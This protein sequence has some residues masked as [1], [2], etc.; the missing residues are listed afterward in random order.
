MQRKNITFS[1]SKINARTMVT[2]VTVVV[3]NKVGQSTFSTVT[4]IFR[5]LP[6]GVKVDTKG[7]AEV[8]TQDT[9]LMLKRGKFDESFDIYD[10]AK[11]L[12][13][14]DLYQ[15]FEKLEQFEWS[16]AK[17]NFVLSPNTLR[18]ESIGIDLPTI[19]SGLT[20]SPEIMWRCQFVAFIRDDKPVFTPTPV[21]KRAIMVRRST[22]KNAKR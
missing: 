10:K 21:A 18:V 2:P 22:L 16:I 13:I 12:F 9:T 11:E 3:S 1:V 14:K 19:P 15:K 6:Y 8:F 5:Y 4:P 7:Y 17:L 20:K